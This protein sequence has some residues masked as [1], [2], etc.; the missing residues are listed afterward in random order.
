MR[1][2]RRSGMLRAATMQNSGL[3]AR[4]YLAAVVSD[5]DVLRKQV[6]GRISPEG[7]RRLGLLYHHYRM[8]GGSLSR[9]RAPGRGDC[10]A[11]GGPALR[12]ENSS[13]NVCRVPSHGR[14][15]LYRRS[16]EPLFRPRI[17]GMDE[18]ASGPLSE[19]CHVPHAG[20]CCLCC[21][22]GWNRYCS[23]NFRIKPTR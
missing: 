14:L 3:T 5:I 11:E 4:E 9:T 1:R 17:T 18:L 8:E 15:R 20:Y 12:H 21:I 6:S 16:E 22:F 13:A 10:R 2:E 7:W 23:D 19:N